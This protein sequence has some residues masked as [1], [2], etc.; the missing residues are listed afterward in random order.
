MYYALVFKFT[1][2]DSSL[3]CGISQCFCPGKGAGQ[4][5]PKEGQIGKV[6]FLFNYNSQT[7][8]TS[9]TMGSTQRHSPQK[10]FNYGLLAFVQEGAG[11]GRLGGWSKAFNQPDSEKG[12]QGWGGHTK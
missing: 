8:R 11:H 2:M 5:L 3:L 7:P 4:G 12:I 1:A 6:S 10:H 9:F